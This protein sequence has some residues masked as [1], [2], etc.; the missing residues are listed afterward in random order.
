MQDAMGPLAGLAGG[1]M[2]G[3]PWMKF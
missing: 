3:F 1:G 2:P